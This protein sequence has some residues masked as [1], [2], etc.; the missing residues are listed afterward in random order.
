M[1]QI[2]SVNDIL[3]MCVVVNTDGTPIACSESPI[4]A[5]AFARCLGFDSPI[6]NMVTI[7]VIGFARK[8]VCRHG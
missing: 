1:S 8:E 3:H 2:A 4:E 6:E 5:A 7:P